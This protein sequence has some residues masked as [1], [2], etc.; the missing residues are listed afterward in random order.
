MTVAQ[1]GPLTTLFEAVAAAVGAG[2]VLGGFTMGTYRLMARQ[3]REELE[4]RV[5]ADGYMGGIVG[6]L[7]VFLDLILRY[8]FPEMSCLY[9]SRG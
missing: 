8:G 6:V 1:I 2:I 4:T 5:L 7:V 3:P 9:G